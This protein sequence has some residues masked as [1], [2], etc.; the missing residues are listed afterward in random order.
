MNIFG[1]C[2]DPECACATLATDFI[3]PGISETADLVDDVL[4]RLDDATTDAIAEAYYRGKSDGAREALDNAS[5]LGSY[6]D[7]IESGENFYGAD[8][9][10][11]YSG[12]L[13]DLSDVDL[14]GQTL[15]L[16]TDELDEWAPMIDANIQY[17]RDGDEATS[18][19]FESLKAWIV[20]VNDSLDFLAN[21]VADIT[22]GQDEMIEDLQERVAELEADTAGDAA[23]LDSDNLT[24]QTV[25][26]RLD[27][28]E[29]YTGARA[30]ELI[31][32]F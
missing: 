23:L 8:G 3:E 26:A 18:V 4:D 2:G 15:L 16:L 14:I 10:L 7:E 11:P 31:G 22:E 9:D 28:L 30:I 12:E 25:L 21:T 5:V 17:L 20:A 29:D 13:D 6:N 27:R 19:V 1:Q 32:S 24:L